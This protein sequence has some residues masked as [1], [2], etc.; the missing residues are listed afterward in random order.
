VLTGKYARPYSE[1][2]QVTLGFTVIIKAAKNHLRP[3]IPAQMPA[4][5]KQLIGTTQRATLLRS[6]HSPTT[7]H[8]LTHHRTR[9]TAHAHAHAQRNAGI[10]SRRTG[11]TVRRC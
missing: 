7:A 1:Y 8:A 6:W 2:P 5:L 9:T 11:P 3:T 4:P 10:R